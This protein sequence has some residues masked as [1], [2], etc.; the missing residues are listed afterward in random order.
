MPVCECQAQSRKIRIASKD[1]RFDSRDLASAAFH[2]RRR[3]CTLQHDFFE[4]SAVAIQSCL[5]TGEVLPANQGDIDVGWLKL[6]SKGDAR[7]FLAGDYGCSRTGKW[8]VDGLT[9]T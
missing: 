8:L 6:D 7:L 4:T 1:L 2:S 3:S 9:G 5:L